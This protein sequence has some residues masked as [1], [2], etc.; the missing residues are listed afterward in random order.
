MAQLHAGMDNKLARLGDSFAEKLNQRA[1]NIITAFEK[2]RKPASPESF[3]RSLK[4]LG[5]IAHKLAGTAGTFGY[6]ALSE[7]AQKLETAI[8][9]GK[10]GKA[11]PR[12]GHID[13]IEELVGNIKGEI[14]FRSWIGAPP[15]VAN[16]WDGSLWEIQD[17]GQLER[18]LIILNDDELLIDL[19]D[20]QLSPAGIKVVGV[21]KPRDLP[22][23]LQAHSPMAL[24]LDVSSWEEGSPVPASLRELK[25]KGMVSCPVFALSRDAEMETRLEAVRAGFDGFIA[26]PLVLTELAGTLAGL[27]DKCGHDPYRVLLVDDCAATSQAN[28][29]LLESAG[30]VARAVNDP[31]EALETALDLRPDTI[32]M[33]VN[34]PG[35]DGFELAA[36]LRQHEC[37]A[38]TPIVF[39]SADGDF[40]RRFHVLRSGGDDFLDK[41]VRPGFLIAAVNSRAARYR[42]L[43]GAINR[44]SESES[45]FSAVAR[46]ATDAIISVDEQDRIVF[47]NQSAEAIFGFAFA[48]IAGRGIEHIIG[49]GSREDYALLTARA[50]R[51]DGRTLSGETIE[52]TGLRKDGSKV[53]VEL[54]A[55]EWEVENQK[56]VT[57][58]IRDISDRKQTAEELADHRD[59]LQQLVDA[60]TRELVAKSEETAAALEV[61]REASKRQRQ[62]ISMASHEFRTPLAIID[63]S[64]H[65]ILK[66]AT[67]FPPGTIDQRVAKIRE[68]VWRM[69]YLIDNTLTVARLDAGK[70]CLR[71]EEFDIAT[72]LAVV[73]ENQQDI[74]KSHRISIDLKGLPKS[75]F[76]DKKK[77]DQVFTNL[78]S[79][80]AKYSFDDPKVEVTG[81]SGDGE[82]IISVKDNGLGIPAAEIPNLFDCYFRASTSMGIP[83]TGLGLH[84]V[85]QILDMHDGDV[86]VSSV[87]GEGTTFTVRLPFENTATA[88][89]G[90]GSREREQ[91]GG[92]RLAN[93]PATAPD[94]RCPPLA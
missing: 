35:C 15:A 31:R 36:V 63:G 56:Y 86:S 85:K 43:N 48:E 12:S 61:E 62:F 75:F 76:G 88:G 23:T 90:N 50:R 60:A 45:R 46:T 33:D 21:S 13:Q 80:A 94:A 44:L 11:G 74:S 2:A 79:N 37:F 28:Q 52:I 14:E 51:G 9:E 20:Q 47:W 55:A 59:H 27:S 34:M 54:S 3:T 70:E 73:C 66:M 92:M 69:I 8:L 82:V 57:A 7:H 84:L 83:G 58:I 77:L 6:T 71:P 19:I 93:P 91:K 53:P 29:A 65:R 25:A 30:M 4:N 42:E 26:K 72:M 17:Y 10:F 16:G 1:A 87:E 67:D 39:L 22:K 38:R 49:A 81:W 41:T 5:N 24:V 18:T 40:D 68:S 32:L 64:A 78:L 89:A